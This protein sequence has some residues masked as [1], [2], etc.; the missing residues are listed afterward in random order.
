MRPRL[1]RFALTV[2]VVSSVGLLGAVVA[3]L[4]LAIVGVA[5]RNA[6]TAGLYASMETI[7]WLVI[8]PFGFAALLSGVVQSLCT[9][10]GL[11]RHYWVL[12]K[13]VLTIGAT[14]LLLL[15][16]GVVD[17]AANIAAGRIPF[18]ANVHSLQT[19]LVF[20]AGLAI[21]VLFVT[22]ALSIYKPWGMTAYGRRQQQRALNHV[23]GS[24]VG[25]LRST[26]QRWV[27][28]LVVIGVF[29]LVV[30]LHLTGVVGRH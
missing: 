7:G 20:D 28:A 11:F 26:Q 10:W 9:E 12:C 18:D 15:H 8:V 19:R 21:M 14:I 16:M 27:Y 17:R 6:S 23:T 4:A 22:T 5:S 24:L 25:D 1:R 2:H 13:F 3:F 29:A 30:I